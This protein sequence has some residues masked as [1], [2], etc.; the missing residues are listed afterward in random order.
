MITHRRWTKSIFQN[1]NP[2]HYDDPSTC[3]L[4]LGVQ[5]CKFVLN[6]KHYVHEPKK[7]AKL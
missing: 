5:L 4:Q 3:P 1:L 6:P 7:Y 2:K